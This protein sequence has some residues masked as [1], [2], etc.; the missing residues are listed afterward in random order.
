MPVNRH[1]PSGS[2][3]SEIESTVQLLD[4]VR[5][6]DETA[7]ED[8]VQRFLPMLRRWAHGRLPSRARDMADTDD[9]VQVSLIKALNKVEGFVPRREGAFLAYLR[10]IVLNSVR[11]E[12]RR[13]ARRPARAPLDRDRPATGPSLVEQ[14]IGKEILDAYEMALAALPD[15]HRE[16][17]IM[18]VEFGYTYQEIAD[19][20]GKPTANAARMTVS[21]ALLRLAEGLDDYRP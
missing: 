16:A 8:L 10:T 15:E 7:R 9:I 21:R 20:L 19:A 18:R 11:D 3:D 12:L 5:S 1:Q 6:G 13:T 2:S 4:R 14:A 17:V